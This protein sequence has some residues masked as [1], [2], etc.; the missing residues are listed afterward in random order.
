MPFT[1]S[2]LSSKEPGEVKSFAL[3]FGLIYKLIEDSKSSSP[4]PLWV[5]L[6]LNHMCFF[7]LHT[8]SLWPPVNTLTFEIW[9]EKRFEIKLAQTVV[10]QPSS[11]G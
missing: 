9:K 8:G 11:G 2:A 3:V 5:P 6:P 1:S 4:P 7:L 10:R